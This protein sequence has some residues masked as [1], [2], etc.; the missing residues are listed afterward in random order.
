MKT[1]I[2]AAVGI[3]AFT[4]AASAVDLNMADPF[5]KTGEGKFTSQTTYATMDQEYEY[6]SISGGTTTQIDYESNY[7]KEE[8]EYG[9]SDKLRLTLEMEY[10]PSEET[11]VG[12]TKGTDDGLTN[13]RVGAIYRVNE[14]K[15]I[16]DLIATFSPDLFDAEDGTTGRDGTVAEGSDELSVSAKFGQV[17]DKVTWAVEGGLSLYTDEEVK[18]LSDDSTDKT[19][20]LVDIDLAVEA[21]YRFNNKLSLNGIIAHTFYA[22]RKYTNTT[23]AGVET[24]DSV[25]ASEGTSVDVAVNYEVDP[26]VLLSAY[27]G[28]GVV[29]DRDNMDSS[30]TKVG[31]YQETEATRLGVTASV[32]F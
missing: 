4:G 31:T 28:Y 10:H 7:L 2:I 13:P 5:Y 27:A 15:F 9:L 1:I 21:Q 24:K 3:F 11:T 16:T 22:E 26:Q 12:G 8:L 6:Y 19:D 17:F 32:K 14:G 23:T 20:S 30:G 29:T 18:D 25:E